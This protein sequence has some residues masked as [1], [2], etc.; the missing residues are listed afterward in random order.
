MQRL[1]V[2]PHAP[3]GASID[4]AAQL[5]SAGG[6]VAIPTDTLYG[7]AVDPFAAAAVSRLFTIKNRAAEKAIPL[8]ASDLAQVREWLGDL[9]PSAMALARQFWPGPLTLVI[10]APPSLDPS[11]V[12]GG[13]TVGV[14]VPAHPVTCALCAAAGRP[15]TATSA[16]L[17]GAPPTDDPNQVIASVGSLIDAILD[18]GKTPGGQPSTIVDVTSAFPRLVREGAVPWDLIQAC[19]QHV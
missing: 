13:T 2:D 17:S 12:G 5:L 1:V 3:G 7:L 14:R 16:N 6:V 8:V 11:V 10:A 9:S 4:A 18:A 19:A 15:L